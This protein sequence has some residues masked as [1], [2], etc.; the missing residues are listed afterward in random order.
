MHVQTSYRKVRKMKWRIIRTSTEQDIV[1]VREDFGRSL[2]GVSVIT[3]VAFEL[4][5]MHAWNYYWV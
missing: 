1:F 4:Q 2:V 3:P 5:G